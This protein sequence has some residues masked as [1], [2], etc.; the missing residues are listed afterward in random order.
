MQPQ[1]PQPA[2]G[3]FGAPPPP[4]AGFSEPSG[5][6]APPQFGDGT[7]PYPNYG[8]QLICYLVTDYILIKS[9]F[10]SL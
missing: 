7:Q 2:A 9:Y 6:P 10:V 4:L 1:Y 3:N 8:K 5:Y